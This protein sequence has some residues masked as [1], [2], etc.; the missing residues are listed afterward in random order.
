MALGAIKS[1]GRVV[2]AAKPAKTWNRAAFWAH[3]PLFQ[4]YLLPS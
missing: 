1:W 3:R 2:P 4:S